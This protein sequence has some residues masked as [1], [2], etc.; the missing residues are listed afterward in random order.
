MR[1]TTLITSQ[2]RAQELASDIAILDSFM[3]RT[4]HVQARSRLRLLIQ[5]LHRA[6]NAVERGDEE[7]V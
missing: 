2:E 3:V 6:L 1:R 5:I 4:H 7:D